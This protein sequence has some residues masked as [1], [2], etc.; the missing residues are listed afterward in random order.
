[1]GQ[2]VDSS[3]WV[4]LFLDFDTQ[5]NQAQKLIQKLENLIYI[6]YCVVIE[7]T[8]VLTYKH[9]KKQADQFLDYIRDNKDFKIIDDIALEEIE[10]FQKLQ[11]RISFVDAALIFLSLKLNARVVT[12]DRQ[13][14][15]LAKAVNHD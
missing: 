13:L 1:M 14:N 12:L 5:H 10:F 2:I 15:R 7:T 9:S 6:P 4:A 8:A 11:Q 3:V